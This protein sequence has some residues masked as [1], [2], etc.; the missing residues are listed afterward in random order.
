[1]KGLKQILI[2]R[3]GL[4]LN[5]VRWFQITISLPEPN[6]IN[7]KILAELILT[8]MKI[9]SKNVPNN[10]MKHSGNNMMAYRKL[11]SEPFRFP[12]G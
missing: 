11:R 6:I 12:W 2:Y 4:C 5:I 1:M 8:R 9:L 10:Q 3:K 7:K